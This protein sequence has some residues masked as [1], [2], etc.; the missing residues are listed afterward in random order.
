LQSWYV[1]SE[2]EKDRYHGKSLEIIIW[3][4]KVASVQL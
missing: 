2:G 3:L 4:G 1:Y